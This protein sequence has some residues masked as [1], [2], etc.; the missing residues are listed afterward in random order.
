MT[1]RFETFTFLINKIKRNISRLK[2]EEM[3]E[4]SLKSSHVNCIYY[5]SRYDSLT[6]T[7]LTELC[8]EDKAA[9]SRSLAHLDDCGL[10]SYKESTNRKKYNTPIVLTEQGRTVAER[11]SKS[12][13]KVLE[14]SSAG[15]DEESRKIMYEGLEIISKNLEKISII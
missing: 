9:I 6:A 4:F 12:I 7:E 3:S 2:A 5:L 14:E 10:V 1:D 11:L 15:L 13:S 8:S